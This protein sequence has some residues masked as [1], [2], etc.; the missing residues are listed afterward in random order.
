[1][2]RGK[3]EMIEA[4]GR[5]WYE[6]DGY[7]C[8]ECVEDD[9]LKDIISINADHKECDYCGRIEDSDCAAPVAT[10][11]ESIGSTLYYYFNEPSSAGVPYEGGYLFE[12]TDT[13]DALMAIGLECNDQ[14]FND[15]SKAFVHDGWVEASGGNWALSHQNEILSSSWD[16]FVSVVKHGVRYF[17]SRIQNSNE[18]CSQEYSPPQLLTI[19]NHLAKE[20]NLISTF[21]SGTSFYRVR[22]REEGANWELNDNQMGS[23]PAEQAAAGRMNPAGI[24]YL[25]LAF[26]QQTALAEVIERPPCGVAIAQFDAKRDL[27]ILDLTA[28][29]TFPSIFDDSR[30]DQR[31]GLLFLSRFVVEISK[32]VKKDGREHI[33]YVPSQVVSE[34]FALSFQANGQP[35]DGIAYPS[36]VRPGGRNLVLFPSKRGGERNFDQIVFQSAREMS[37]ANWTVLTT[38]INDI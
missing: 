18:S 29:P 21:P 8:D 36:A 31:E 14:L 27:Q 28:L 37:F 25:Y 2:G 16:N 30:R 32:P 7:V 9:F 20:L 15:I 6:P 33:E 19:I 24:S 22:E 17:F 1:M 23:P 4:E 3:Q 11:M 35:L 5:G 10:I 34:Y 26:D 12:P 13:D 38:A